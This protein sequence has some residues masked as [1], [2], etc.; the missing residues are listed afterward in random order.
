MYFSYLQ[1][2]WR[3]AQCQEM[4]QGCFVLVSKKE[5]VHA[6]SRHL[7]EW[8]SVRFVCK[9]QEFQT[10]RFGGWISRN[11]FSSKGRLSCTIPGSKT[12]I[13]LDR[14][15]PVRI[16]SLVLPSEL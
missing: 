11:V 3:E 15:I 14:R 8:S 13:T 9:R 16:T 5:A 10:K 4:K 12:E 6:V 7:M 2:E 1:A